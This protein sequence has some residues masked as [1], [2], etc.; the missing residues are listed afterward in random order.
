MKAKQFLFIYLILLS[1]N[2]SQSNAQPAI[3]T[4]KVM[5]YNVGNFGTA[6]TTS[7]PLFN[8]NLKS[9]YLR[10]ILKYENPDIIGMAK[11]NGD[12]MFCTD[13]IV[14]L[15]LDS[16][17]TGCWGY[18]NYSVVSTYPKENMLYFNTNKFG[19]KSSTVIYSGDPN[20][21]DITL[22][23]LY[24]K[25]PD[26]AITHDTI[27]LKI[28]LAH[29]LSGSGSTSNRGLEV[30]GAMTWLNAN[31]GSNEN[32]IFMGDLNTTKSTETCFQDL[33]SS[34]NIN[35][36]FFDPPGQLGNWSASP[37]LF[38]NYLTQSTRTTDPGD[39]NATGGLSNRFD[40]ILLTTPL[41]TGT[42][43]MEYIAGSYKVI[44]QDGLHTNNALTDSP[45]NISVPANVN[46]ALYY[47]SEHLP[48]KLYLMIHNNS[49]TAGVSSIKNATAEIKIYPNPFTSTTT[50]VFSEDE[51]HKIKITDVYG[52]EVKTFTI[53][54][55]QCTIGKGEMSKGIY[56]VQ[57]TDGQKNICNRKIVIQ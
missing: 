46:S 32:L 13:T 2:I 42:D 27:F 50:I 23:K 22:H 25:S 52:K 6:P 18:G 30:A 43:S 19:F 5:T 28:V 16:L 15:V 21:S 40:H 17:C 33:I 34:P 48:V 1:I 7:C 47:M 10:T 29:L 54:G 35:T 14:N 31:I 55:K 36:K 39:C 57:I 12:E 3:D 9:G 44:G 56:F 37:T 8:F 45:T 41:M 4:I 24:Y 53:S 49:T 51:W 38:A 11:I 26:L 20:I